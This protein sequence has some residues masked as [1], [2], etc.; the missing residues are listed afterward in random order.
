MYVLL[1]PLHWEVTRLLYF[2]K[3]V[4]WD[5][6][7][8]VSPPHPPPAARVCG[9]RMGWADGWVFKGGRMLVWGGDSN[10][11]KRKLACVGEI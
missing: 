11:E 2:I 1:F 10:G 8:A 7:D 6:G 5:T 4:F 9:W 3:I